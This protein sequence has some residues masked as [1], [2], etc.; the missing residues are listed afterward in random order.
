M[1]I[2]HHIES[3]LS[4]KLLAPIFIAALAIF[5]LVL[6]IIKD[7][8]DRS[9]K[10]ALTEESEHIAE[11]Y[12]IFSELDDDPYQL[13]RITNAIAANDSVLNLR[14][15]NNDNLTV[16]ADSQN[17]NIG[18][19]VH[20]V[21]SNDEVL[22]LQE[23]LNNSGRNK[24]E[25]DRRNKLIYTIPVNIIT[26]K[27]NRLRL[28]T[29]LLV[30]D[31]SSQAKQAQSIVQ[32]A[33]A[34][35][36]AGLLVL[37]SIVV[38]AHH[39]YLK[40]PLEKIRKTLEDQRHSEN[41]IPLNVNS[42]DEIGEIASAYNNTLKTQHEQKLQLLEVHKYIDGITEEAPVQLAY[43][44]SKLNI[45]F[46][47]K[48]FKNFYNIKSIE[49]NTTNIASAFPAEI[50]TD[51]TSRISTLEQNIPVSF[52][53][54]LDQ[55]DPEKSYLLITLAP[56]ISG[57]GH[58]DGYF[59]CIEDQS[60]IKSAEE[61]LV[62]YTA[63]L[64]FKTWDLE[65]AKESA[66][67]S[68]R[69][70]S[71]FLAAMSHEIRTPING[72]LGM[73]SLLLKEGLNDKQYH[74][75]R[76][77]LSS[78]ESLLG[79]IN[80]ILDFSKIEAGK[81]TIEN[82]PF[83]IY[84][85]V[86]RLIDSFLFRA[87]DKSLDF[88]AEISINTPMVIVG[89]P[90]RIT[91]IITNY[92]NNALK[93][94]QNGSIDVFIGIKSSDTEDL[95]L[96]GSVKDTGIGIPEEKQHRLFQSFSQVDASTTREYGGTG[97]GLA[98][99]KKLATLMHGDAGCEST[100][101][102]GSKFWFEVGVSLPMVATNLS[103]AADNVVC[104]AQ[105][106]AD[107]AEQL[108]RLTNLWPQKPIEVETL[109]DLPNIVS[110]AK[111][112]TTA[113]LI[114]PEYATNRTAD[115][116]ALVQEIRSP[117]V[118]IIEVS[119]QENPKAPTHDWADIVIPRML[120]GVSFYRQLERINDKR[121]QEE[122]AVYQ[123]RSEA[124]IYVLLVEDND[125]N[126]EVA[127]GM[128]HDLGA[129]VDIAQNGLEALTFL[130]SQPTRYDM[131]FMDCQ[132]PHLDGYETSRVIRRGNFAKVDSK[133][134]IIAMTANAMKGDQEACLEAG[135]SDYISKPVDF[136][137]LKE[138]VRKWTPKRAFSTRNGITNNNP[139]ANG[140]ENNSSDTAQNIETP[141]IE[142]PNADT[143]NTTATNG[144][145]ESDVQQWDRET[146]MKR[147]RNKPDRALKLLNL[148]CNDMPERM[149]RMHQAVEE[150]NSEKI[151]TTAHEI[152]GVCANLSAN[153]MSTLAAKLETAGKANALDDVSHVY[154]EMSE[155]FESLINTLNAE[156]ASLEAE[157]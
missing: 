73:L 105:K 109:S 4:L 83:N 115:I 7:I 139:L 141:S 47:N 64:E 65:E 120:S 100:P 103:S 48:T 108:K 151:F 82:I 28:Y 29:L 69:A 88:N 147:I 12:A 130:A 134:P 106:G 57:K 87:K 20:D 75:A 49:G 34:G 89:D 46:S 17:E 142:T 122:G 41:P 101:G 85:L 56:D 11:N 45:K 94:T 40:R 18:K 117:N 60:A 136:D 25:I 2:K 1:N 62:E 107:S 99:V 135:M 146:F 30:L 39:V 33:L 90:T 97:L 44:D 19:H 72:V 127:S 53:V 114:E 32:Y 81:L 79:V 74:Y 3:S 68:T 67:A 140:S 84:D 124:H 91:Q 132:M 133:I 80:D 77:A 116:D 10:Q 98:I 155:A 31:K 86:S 52:E 129:Y 16:L 143:Q 37:L 96:Y 111:G 50:Y 113:I 123:K 78:G 6:Y 23:H 154:T 61:K 119:P 152:K 70:K 71:E 121:V 14:L 112:K 9:I 110:K 125:I 156:R 5:S 38:L 76:L 13:I 145:A 118:C 59:L 27:Q 21:L 153:I 128:L 102:E 55:G 63:E 66:E 54:E 22:L 51:I 92:L 138:K 150:G 148:F 26:A 95:C 24:H 43:F 149:Q 144:K 126:Q 15:I 58:V 35:L 42:K 8:S 36:I 157:I 104:I 131:V 93:F 137:I